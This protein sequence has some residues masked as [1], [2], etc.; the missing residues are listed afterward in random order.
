MAGAGGQAGGRL[1]GGTWSVSGATGCLGRAECLSVTLQKTRAPVPGQQDWDVG[2]RVVTAK[3]SR[4][5]PEPWRTT[6]GR[7]LCRSLLV[8]C[9]P[10]E[11][12]STEAGLLKT[13]SSGRRLGSSGG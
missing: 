13:E 6:S 3:G 8:V 9:C 2:H 11:H 12:L 4:S 10:S 1:S 7:V 5:I